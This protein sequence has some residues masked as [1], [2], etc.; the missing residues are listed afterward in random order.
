MTRMLPWG[1][2]G[3]TGGICVTGDEISA[4]VTQRGRRDDG[5]KRFV[6]DTAIDARWLHTSPRETLE[7][8]KDD[9]ELAVYRRAKVL[10]PRL[11]KYIEDYEHYHPKAKRVRP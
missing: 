9:T 2:A 5:T 6:A 11:A 7:E 3:R 10:L 8:A 1:E 4:S